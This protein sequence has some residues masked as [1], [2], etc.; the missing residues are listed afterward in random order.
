MKTGRNHQLDLEA[1]NKFTHEHEPIILKQSK[2]EKILFAHGIQTSIFFQSISTCPKDNSL[3]YHPKHSNSLPQLSNWQCH[4]NSCSGQDFSVTLDLLLSLP[5]NQSTNKILLRSF[6]GG[7]DVKEY[8]CNPGDPDSIPGERTDNP[9][10]S[11]CLP[12]EVHGQR[13]LAGYSP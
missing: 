1:K 11:V 9:F 8:A 5:H 6:P 12:G 7:S 13:S 2:D 4:F 10:Q 3:L